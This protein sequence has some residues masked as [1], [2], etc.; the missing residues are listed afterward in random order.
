MTNDDII[1]NDFLEAVICFKFKRADYNELL[2]IYKPHK[3]DLNHHDK[4]IPYKS[5]NGDDLNLPNDDMLCRML[6]GNYYTDHRSM[7][8]FDVTLKGANMILKIKLKGAFEKNKGAQNL[9]MKHLKRHSL[10][11]T[12]QYRMNNS[13]IQNIIVVLNRDWKF[14]LTSEDLV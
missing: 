12:E 14:K 9:V 11:H 3:D 7:R 13:D 4:I 2:R 5:V 1:I 10:Y 6:Y 8:C